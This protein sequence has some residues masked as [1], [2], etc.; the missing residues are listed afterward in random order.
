[1]RERERADRIFRINGIE[2]ILK[3]PV[4]PLFPEE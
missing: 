4:R 2:E 3:Y 1:L